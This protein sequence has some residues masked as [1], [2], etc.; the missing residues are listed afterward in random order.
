MFRAVVS[1]AGAAARACRTQIATG[2]AGTLIAVSLW[3]STASGSRSLEKAQRQCDN[4]W[5]QQT[6]IDAFG[7]LP[8]PCIQPCRGATSA[9]PMSKWRVFEVRLVRLPE[10]RLNALVPELP[11]MRK[12]AARL[13][14][15]GLAAVHP[16]GA[17]HLV[18]R[19]ASLFRVLSDAQSQPR[20]APSDALWHFI[21]GKVFPVLSIGSNISKGLEVWSHLCPI[22]R[23]ERSFP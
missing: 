1:F 2:I 11:E 19:V 22:W 18:P 10:L 5:R 7:Q 12:P 8:A 17:F 13:P 15:Y 4:C 21:L 23:R 3:L 6:R 9:T 14:L 20:T 16:Q